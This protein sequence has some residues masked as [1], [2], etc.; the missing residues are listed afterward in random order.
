M[1]NRS[2]AVSARLKP[3][4]NA[5]SCGVGRSHGSEPTL[6][7]L[8]CRPGAAAPIEPLAWK[9]PNAIGAALKGQKDKRK[10]KA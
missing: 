8:W 7:W 6:L 1:F 9:P 10:I 3:S 4:G 2:P 5:V